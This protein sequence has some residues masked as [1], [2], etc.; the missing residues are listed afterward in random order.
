MFFR[1]QMEAHYQKTVEARVEQAHKLEVVGTLAAG[2]AHDFNNLLG[3]IIGFAE[4]AGDDL[5]EDSLRK[6]NIL[7][8]LATS[9]RARDLVARLLT[10]A[11]QSP[12]VAVPVDMVGEVRE[13]LAL[14]RVS[15]PPGLQLRYRP[16]VER[17][18]VLA[19]PVQ[20]QQIVM[21]LCMNAADAMAHQGVVDVS[22][23][24]VAPAE[25][26]SGKAGVRLTVA[27]CGHGML[28]EVQERIFDPFFTTK[29]PSQ[30]SGLGLSVV[31][32]IVTHLGGA[33]TVS[34]RAGGPR[35]GT[36]FQVTL[37]LLENARDAGES[38][39]DVTTLAQQRG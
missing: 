30:G 28:P 20:I 32:G 12:G 1:E 37:P 11:R 4:L 22:V 5:P 23:A 10:F 19:D 16:D 6:H 21:N 33:I 38:I 29:A 14:L 35:R 18:M 8:I 9:F 15:Y 34:S 26:A 3:S 31:Y 36:E 13:S 2:I 25:N 39:H 17:A 24:A 7:Q 27:D